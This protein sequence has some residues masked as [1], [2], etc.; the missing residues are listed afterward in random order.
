M[1]SRS[2]FSRIGRALLSSTICATLPVASMAQSVA[3]IVFVVD[4]S[5]SMSGEHEFLP[6]FVTGIENSLASEGITANF[7]LT[8]FGGGGP[9][10]S[11]H[12][13]MLDGAL[14]GD[15]LSFGTAAQDLVLTG[16]TED[17]YAALDFALDSYTF[18][19]G[20]SVTFVL[21]TDED[22]DNTDAALDAAGIEAG[23]D[24]VGGS[25]VVVVDADIETSQGEIGI[26]TDGTTVLVQAGSGTA[27]QGFATI[28]S[29]QG[30]TT[31]DYI[32][33]ALNT[34]N[35]C[36][37]DLKYLRQGGSDADA[38]A[39][40]FA[41]CV[42]DA[43]TT[44]NPSGPTAG[45]G[46]QTAHAQ[47]SI[48]KII[49]ISHG[50]VVA[51]FSPSST[52]TGL[53]STMGQA[54]SPKMNFSKDAW[55]VEGL[56]FYMSGSYSFGTYDSYGSNTGFDF[57][58]TGATFGL[59]YVIPDTGEMMVRAG[60]ALSY[61][62]VNADLDADEADVDGTAWTLS[63]YVAFSRPD[64]IHGRADLS[65]SA[66]DYDQVRDPL[67]GAGGP[68]RSSTDGDAVQLSAEIGKEFVLAGTS[69]WTT[70]VDPFVGLTYARY[71]V[72]GYQEDNGGTLVESFDDDSLAPEIG[73]R[74]TWKRPTA[75]GM[76]FLFGELAYSHEL[77]DDDT[78]IA[79]NGGTTTEL[80]D[81]VDADM[82][83]TK[84]AVGTQMD[85]GM[86]AML[87][88]EGDFTDHS[89]SHTITAGL[90]VAF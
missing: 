33:L 72:D 41:T 66:L 75:Q 42:T 16:G 83:S 89:D 15:A 20:A 6:D 25:L 9:D 39:E 48:Q 29:N 12:T 24:G 44:P 4:E 70:I 3:D 76:L 90:Q 22:R 69:D 61:S 56:T 64:G 45:N 14:F 60:G 88:Y 50:R 52:G 86:T 31:E 36:V 17:G 53:V 68:F 23:I 37:A 63:S 11:G 46:T 87:Q 84:L 8:G 80:L 38:F 71:E 65:Y 26:S 21:V 2:A 43:A 7:G 55:G 67:G 85:N 19:P 47:R 74:S 30:T 28:G 13:F 10:N 73:I 62:S 59:D 1:Q 79:I 32:Q 54:I 5:G 77:R 27:S 57:D 35:G 58:G 40:A 18:T 78:S 49:L 82:L 34:A 51:T 81:S